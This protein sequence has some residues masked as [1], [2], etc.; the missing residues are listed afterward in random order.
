VA[1]AAGAVRHGHLGRGPAVGAGRIVGFTE[2]RT[3]SGI[4]EVAAFASLTALAL[5]SAAGRQP[6]GAGGGSFVPAR[7][8]A[9]VPGAGWL[10]AAASVFALVVLGVSAGV[11]GGAAPTAAGSLKTAKIGGVCSPAPGLHPLLMRA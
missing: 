2:V 1:V 8:H 6:A 3:T 11:A 10:V 5:A 4:I 7:L 9:G